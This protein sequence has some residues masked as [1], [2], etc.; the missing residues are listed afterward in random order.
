MQAFKRGCVVLLPISESAC[1]GNSATTAPTPA[2]PSA[3]S[4]TPVVVPTPGPSPTLTPAPTPNVSTHV[5]GLSEDSALRLLSGVRIEI[6]DGPQTGAS[7]VT[8]H[9][10]HFEFQA[11]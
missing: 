4:P 7:V 11:H 9:D 3:V 8:G 1:G 6:V 10:G 2:L 5:S